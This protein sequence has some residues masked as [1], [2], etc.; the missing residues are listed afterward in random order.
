MKTKLSENLKNEELLKTP[1]QK[2]GL[3]EF[4]KRKRQ[5]KNLTLDRLS[6][7]TKIQLYHLEALES[8]QF[9]KLPPT[10]YC[11]GIFKR[12]SKFLDADENEI[13]ETYKNKIESST[14][15]KTGSAPIAKRES[16]FILTPSKLMIF[17][18]GLLLL[19]LSGYL[20]YQFNFLI[21]PPNLAIKP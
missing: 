18:G 3:G 1:V 5:E 16:Y 17:A 11:V 7:L 20:W 13:I 6:D 8:G 15:N 4:L 19:L 12:L 10:V 14:S 2:T 9:E 21:G